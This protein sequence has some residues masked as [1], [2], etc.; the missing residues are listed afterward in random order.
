MVL[1]HNLTKSFMARSSLTRHFVLHFFVPGCLCSVN[2]ATNVHYHFGFCIRKLYPR[3]FCSLFLCWTIVLKLFFRFLDQFLVVRIVKNSVT[4]RDSAWL[5]LWHL[6]TE[7]PE[8][9]VLLIK[10]LQNSVA[11]DKVV[12]RLWCSP[13]RALLTKS[14]F[15]SLGQ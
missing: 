9:A 2:S 13:I 12:A 11:H 10:R 8:M 3:I 14:I 15:Y 5:I 1:C 6:F 7:L 4:A